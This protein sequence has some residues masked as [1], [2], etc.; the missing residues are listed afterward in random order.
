LW[1]K[2]DGHVFM[3][4][5]GV[6]KSFRPTTTRNDGGKSI[7]PGSENKNHILSDGWVG[8]APGYV[9]ATRGNLPAGQG[10]SHTEMRV[11]TTVDKKKALLDNINKAALNPPNYSFFIGKRCASFAMKMMRTS[12]VVPGNSIFH[13]FSPRALENYMLRRPGTKLLRP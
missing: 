3:I 10:Y 4:I 9:G 6:D 7:P 1:G 12:K 11:R 5:N 2:L 13:Q 8:S